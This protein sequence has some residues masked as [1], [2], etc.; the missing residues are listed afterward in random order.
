MKT[1][2]IG[3]SAAFVLNQKILVINSFLLLYNAI[4]FDEVNYI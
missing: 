1:D 2:V 4:S 3:G